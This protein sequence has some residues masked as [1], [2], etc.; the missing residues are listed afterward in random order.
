[1]RQRKDM[2]TDYFSC[3]KLNKF[4]SLFHKERILPK[5]KYCQTFNVNKVLR[6]L[7]VVVH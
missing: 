7:Y 3:F 2:L 4:N 6:H 5:L 1:M